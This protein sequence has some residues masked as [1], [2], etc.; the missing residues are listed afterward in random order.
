ML[1]KIGATSIPKDELNERKQRLG[2]KWEK[3]CL[4][5]LVGSLDL[6][7]TDWRSPADIEWRGLKI[8]VKT[9]MPTY[10]GESKDR[11]SWTFNTKQKNGVDV[12]LCI[13]LNENEQLEKVFWI[14]SIQARRMIT[15]RRN[16]NTKYE[17]FRTTFEKL[18]HERQTNGY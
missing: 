11:K 9:S 10:N 6:S 2:R 8:N 16:G 14:P 7:G 13:G 15:I 18:N 5:S 17:C 4:K 3:Y 12:F 1:K